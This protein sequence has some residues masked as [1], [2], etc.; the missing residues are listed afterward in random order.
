MDDSTHMKYLEL[1]LFIETESRLEVTCGQVGRQ[2]Y[3]GTVSFGVM[4]MFLISGDG[5]TIL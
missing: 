1:A 3:T 4:K 5:C 2:C